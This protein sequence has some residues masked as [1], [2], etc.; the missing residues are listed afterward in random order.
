MRMELEPLFVV[1]TRRRALALAGEDEPWALVGA[2]VLGSK[3]T[4]NPC[5]L[6]LCP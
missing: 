4:R 3:L 2:E 5:P 6:I 1:P